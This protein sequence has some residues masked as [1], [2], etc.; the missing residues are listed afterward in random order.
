MD[1]RFGIALFVVLSIAYQ[2]HGA[3]NCTATGA[4]RFAD[5]ADTTCKNYTLC[6]LVPN[7]NTFV[8]Y[9]YV[10]PTTSVFNPASKRCTASSNFVCNVTAP[11]S[12]TTTPAPPAVCTA[13]GYVADPSVTDCTSYIECV[14]INGTFTQTVYTCPNGTLYN[15]NTTLCEVNYVC[16]FTCT[17][18]GRYA[19]PQDAN[20]KTYFMCVLNNNGSF[21]Q[22]Q[23]TC[24]STSVFSPIAR[25]CTTSY[26]CNN[27]G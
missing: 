14:Q 19:N 12:T 17:A 20:C 21:S 25:M 11:G 23:Y 26:T 4:G 15:P 27:S 22:Y 24:P 3:V 13:D 7:T 6:V 8:A 2:A 9:N 1:N 10:C 16:P 18:S 5:P